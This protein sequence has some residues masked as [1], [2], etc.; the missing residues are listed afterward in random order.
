MSRLRS[1][2][3]RQPSLREHNLALV[4]HEVAERGP[5]SR[6]RISAATGLTKATVSTLVESLVSAGLLRELGP[7]AAVGVGRPGSGLALAPGPVGIGIEINVDYL[8]TC[9]VDLTGAVRRRELVAEDFRQLGVPAALSRAASALRAAVDD[10]A[11]SGS[12]VAGVT[13]AVPG[14]V[15]ASRHLVR[16]APNLGWRDV[17]VLDELSRRWDAGRT[18]ATPLPVNLRLDNEANLA[19]L[20][21]LWCGN[22][23][24]EDGAPLESFVHVSGEIGVGAAIVLE[25]RLFVGTRGFS[26]ELG[27]LPLAPDGPACPCGSRGCLEQYAGQD[28]VLR[29]AGL[30][31]T[32]R[33]TNGRPDGPLDDLVALAEAGRP[34]VLA[35]IR[36]AGTALGTGIAVLL[37]LVDVET[38]ILGGLYARLAPWLLE[39]VRARLAERVLTAGWAPPRVLVSG[40]G[41]DGAVRGAATSAVRAVIDDPAAWIA[42][43][44]GGR[45]IAPGTTDRGSSPGVTAP[46]TVA[47]MPHRLL[48]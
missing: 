33:T 32:A 14:L 26:G 28:A 42:A 3:A 13:V 47:D 29:A 6:A 48:R 15:E 27:H 11:A 46:G 8:A 35:A 25:G 37:N 17:P 9:T 41:A 5:L 24:D 7:D 18:A 2:P 34:R 21:E 20:A 16:L 40:L 30:E 38:V 4:L 31:G 19:A 36:S 22:H 39:P 44:A 45:E 1:V 43:R 10:A 23:R 12:E